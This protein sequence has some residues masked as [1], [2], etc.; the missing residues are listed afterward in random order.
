VKG[1]LIKDTNLN[2]INVTSLQTL[3]STCN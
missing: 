1:V 2:R 3:A